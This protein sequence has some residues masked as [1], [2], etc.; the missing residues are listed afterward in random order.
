MGPGQAGFEVTRVT[1]A[2]E[3][4]PWAEDRSDSPETG[5]AHFMRFQTT[6][7]IYIEEAPFLVFFNDKT[8]MQ[9]HDNKNHRAEHGNE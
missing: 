3:G 8:D 4:G 5:I 2:S 7:P 9:I 1:G 6:F